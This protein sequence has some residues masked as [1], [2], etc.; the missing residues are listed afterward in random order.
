MIHQDEPCYLSHSQSCALQKKY[1][2]GRVGNPCYG[3]RFFSHYASAEDVIV[4]ALCV[5]L[6][7]RLI[8]LAEWTYRLE[9]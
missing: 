9:F 8:I 7:V 1:Q 6:S 2:A 4:L 3:L 5:C